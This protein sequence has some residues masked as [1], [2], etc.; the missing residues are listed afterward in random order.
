MGDALGCISVLR[1]TLPRCVRVLVW[2][3]R[4][5][6]RLCK[7]TLTRRGH[8]CDASPSLCALSYATPRCR[9]TPTWT[10]TGPREKVEV[11]SAAEVVLRHYLM[12][13]EAQGR[14]TKSAVA[15]CTSSL[16]PTAYVLFV[17]ASA[18]MDALPKLRETTASEPRVR[19]WHRA[20]PRS[21]RDNL[22][23]RCAAMGTHVFRL[24]SSGT[25]T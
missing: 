24:T 19:E 6:P 16:R 21:L 14:T 20:S 11:D 25:R 5:R 9:R 7:K 4:V 2:D 1:T 18:R 3:V 10:S 12:R 17:H 22:G 8:G 15:R 13:H 23:T